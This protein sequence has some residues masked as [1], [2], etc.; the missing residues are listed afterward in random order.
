[1]TLQGE[2]FLPNVHEP[3]DVDFTQ[4]PTEPER[5]LEHE[6]L[7]G[8]KVRIRGNDD[9]IRRQVA[10]IARMINVFLHGETEVT[11]LEDQ[12]TDDPDQLKIGLDG[13]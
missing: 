10:W 8:F 13:D 5:E 2:H 6:L 12:I 11:I 4:P 1:M 3:I 9:V 7:L